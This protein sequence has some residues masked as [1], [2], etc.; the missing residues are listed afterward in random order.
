MI[1]SDPYRGLQVNNLFIVI[2]F[3]DVQNDSWVASAFRG[4]TK[5]KTEKLQV[6][7]G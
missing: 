5:G 4:N 1:S 3:L 7:E 6:E 2:K